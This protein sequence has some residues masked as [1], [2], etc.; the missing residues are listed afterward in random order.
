VSVPTITLQG[1][2]GKISAIYPLLS[3]DV[4]KEVNRIPYATLLFADGNAAKGKFDA[5]ESDEF[6]LGAEIEV[7][8][9]IEGKSGAEEGTLFKGPV[10]RHGIEAGAGGS[11]LRSNS[12]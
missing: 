12:L 7:R 8:L 2:N 5:S 10:V 9:R 3:V 11:P 1:K 4:R 6:E